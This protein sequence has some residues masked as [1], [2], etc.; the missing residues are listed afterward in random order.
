MALKSSTCKITVLG[1]YPW[2]YLATY[3]GLGDIIIRELRVY[4]S[5]MSNRGI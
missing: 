5:E 1:N 3:E 2:N 4:S